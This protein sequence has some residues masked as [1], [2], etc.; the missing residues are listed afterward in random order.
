MTVAVVDPRGYTP[1]YD[2]SLC[3]ALARAGCKVR[4]MTAEHGELEWAPDQSYE[5]WTGFCDFTR[6]FP[7]DGSC[8][9]V[10][11]AMQAGDYLLSIANFLAFVGRETPDVLHFQWLPLPLFDQLYL[12]HLRR[13]SKLVLTLH[14]TTF[15]HGAVSQARAWGLRAALKLF[16]AVVVHTNF[17]RRR[18][19]ERGWIEEERLHVV[20]HGVFDHYG[21]ASNQQT[22]RSA[23]KQLLFFG[24]LQPYKGVDILLR[25]FA[26]LDRELLQKTT[27]VIAG[28]PIMD[29]EPLFALARELGIGHRVRWMLR[30]IKEEEVSTLFHAATAV[31]LPYREIDQ[32]G[33][34]M[35]AIACG[36]PVLASA[37]GG[38]PETVQDGIHGCLVPP[39]DSEALAQATTRLLSSD[40]RLCEMREAVEKLR[41]GRFSWNHI[42][43]E[44]TKIYRGLL[45]DSAVPMAPPLAAREAA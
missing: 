20:P 19:L 28:R 1:P 23:E 37:V 4:L 7:T 31:V 5:R 8:T 41:E 13:R 38:I 29:P 36:K 34:L 33:V 21:A 12:R 40:G 43:A 11:K 9:A 35:T 26:K 27:L 42:S 15:F 10:Q 44:T 16:D 45:T 2:Q 24:N 6:S 25:A 17:S 32:S 18:V 30:S 39:D 3:A 22:D 14:N